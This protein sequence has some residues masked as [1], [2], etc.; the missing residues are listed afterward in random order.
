MGVNTF[1]LFVTLMFVLVISARL[2]SSAKHS[3]KSHKKKINSWKNIAVPVANLSFIGATQLNTSTEIATSQIVTTLSPKTTDLSFQ[4]GNQTL[5]NLENTLDNISPGL[6]ANSERENFVAN[7]FVDDAGTG[8][9]VGNSKNKTSNM[10][11]EVINIAP[12][13]RGR[14]KYSKRFALIVT[15]Y[16]SLALSCIVMALCLIRGIQKRNKRHQQYM[17]LTKRDLDFPLGGGGI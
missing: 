8:I 5:N 10:I 2:H 14:S 3:K 11:L 16:A 9:D 12:Y 7:P 4:V 15:L 17:L 1:K 6:N 13:F